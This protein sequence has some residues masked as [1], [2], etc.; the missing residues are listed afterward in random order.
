M[1]YFYRSPVGIF[2]IVPNRDGRWTLGVVDDV[3]LGSY[4]SPYAAAGDVYAQATG[5]DAW[6]M[7]P[8]EKL[9]Y[10]PT[11]LGEWDRLP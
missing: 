3:K 10:A 9:L 2:Y 4:H 6:D 7:L 5:Y 11:D 1:R 8:V